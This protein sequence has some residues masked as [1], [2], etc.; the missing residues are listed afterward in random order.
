MVSNSVDSGVY[1]VGYSNKLGGEI[2]MRLIDADKLWK[3]TEYAYGNVYRYYEA[4]EVDEAPTIEAVEVVRCKD[5]ILDR[6]AQCPM[7]YATEEDDY[8]SF[9]ERAE[10]EIN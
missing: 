3:T 4:W 10:N 8:C 2:S 5:C 6:E 1:S 7:K 9:G